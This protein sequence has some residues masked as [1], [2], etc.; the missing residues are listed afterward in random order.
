LLL[1]SALAADTPHCEC[2]YLLYLAFEQDIREI[3]K[4]GV[5]D[6]FNGKGSFMNK[7]GRRMPWL[8]LLSEDECHF[9]G[10]LVIEIRNDIL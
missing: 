6:A 3:P 8:N 9:I 4:F 7:R 1:P 10:V 2:L 5:V